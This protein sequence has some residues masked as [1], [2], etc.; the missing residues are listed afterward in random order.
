MTREV[1]HL[2]D[3]VRRRFPVFEAQH[4]LPDASLPYECAEVD[5]HVDAAEFFEERGERQWRAAVVTFDERGDALSD[6]IL[7]SGI[8]E[9][10]TAG[11]GMNVDKTGRDCQPVGID[12]QL[13]RRPVKN[14]DGGDG[15]A[16]GTD[17][18]LVPRVTR[19]IHDVG[20]ANDDVKRLDLEKKAQCGE[21]QHSGHCTWRGSA[22]RYPTLTCA[23]LSH[24]GVRMILGI[25]PRR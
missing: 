16:L 3:F 5:R 18:A 25:A 1:L 22:W 2:C 9:D 10:S 20:M 13:G 8:Q 14:T 15:V 4:C 21:R 11:V 17:V 19:P 24:F 7:R 6:V 12:G 23:V